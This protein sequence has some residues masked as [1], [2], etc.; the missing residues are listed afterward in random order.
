MLFG[1]S[2]E[3]DS[4]SHDI[5]LAVEGLPADKFFEFYGALLLSL[6]KAVDLV[7]LNTKNRFTEFIL[8][9]GRVIYG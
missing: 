6:S 9:K 8:R 1:S 2:L 4:A 3:N 7:D 5:N